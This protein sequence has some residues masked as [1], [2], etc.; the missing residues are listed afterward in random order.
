[1]INYFK[2]LITKD[3]VESIIKVLKTNYLTQ[4]PETKK[5]I[6]EISEYYKSRFTTCFSD[7][8]SGLHIGCLVSEIKKTT[9]YGH[10]KLVLLCQ[11]ISSTK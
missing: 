9:Q 8:I 11:Q 7:A 6:K 5:F 4:D 10:L 3:G 2:Q 1:M